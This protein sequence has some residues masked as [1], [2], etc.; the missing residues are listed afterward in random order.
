[1]MLGTI[2]SLNKK[3]K[4]MSG[5]IRLAAIDK[6]LMEVFK[7]TRLDKVLKIYPKTDDA[8]VKFAS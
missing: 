2:M 8:L 5:E 3:V 1:A 4:G 6:Q 7:L